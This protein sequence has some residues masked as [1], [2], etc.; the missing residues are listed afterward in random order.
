M[1]NR[2]RHSVQT[3]ERLR[4]PKEDAAPLSRRLYPDL[5]EMKSLQRAYVQIKQNGERNGIDPLAL[6]VVE[7]EGVETVLRHLRN[8]LQA[9]SYE[10]GR[11]P[12]QSSVSSVSERGAVV[13]LRDLVVQ[14]T[15]RPLLE[16][17]FPPAFPSDPE[18]EK[19]I[20]WLAA[21][22]DRGLTRVYT[23]NVEESSGP[24]QHHRLVERL[25]QRIDD[26]D[27]IR[28]LAKFLETPDKEGDPHGGLLAPVL[29]NI[30]FEKIDRLLQQVETLGRQANFT[31]VKCARVD[32]ELI[33]LVDRD[34]HYDWVLPAVQKR[35][36]EELSKLKYNIDHTNTQL[37]DLAL[38]NKLRFLGF[39]LR[40]VRDRDGKTR[41]H[42]KR[43]VKTARRR[44]ARPR[45]RLP[46]RF[47]PLRFV[48]PCLSWME[49]WP[50]WRLVQ[51]AYRKANSVQASWRHLPITLYPVLTY[52]LGW[53]SPFA[54]LCLALIFVCNWRG[55]LNTVRSSGNWAGRH[56]L[57][58]VM[59][60][61]AVAA[62]I[63]VYPFVSNMYAN[64]PREAAASSSLPPGFYVGEY[65][66]AEWWSSEPTPGLSYGLYVPPHL[67]G[68]KG[69]FPLIV[70]LHGYGE[71]TKKRIFKAGLPLAIARRFGTNSPN[72]PFDFVA[73]FPIDPTGKWQAGSAE[74]QDA[75][76]AL[77]Y[78]IERHR[79]D[80]SR[81]YLTGL[82]AGGSGVW[83]LA[84]AHP[85]KWAA[86]APLCSFISPDVAKV[87]HLPAWI[88]HGAKDRQA[89]VERE[90][91]LVQQ[92]KEAKADVRY[93][94]FPNNE[95]GIW[96]E[97]YEPKELYSWLA[98]KKKN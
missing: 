24:E 22:I 13:A 48:R 91:I 28:L 47:N 36:R 29:G 17:I 90:R 83:S 30:A 98:S 88:F 81:V 51:H 32:H 4:P 19:T 86:V 92:L 40:S 14:A 21:N 10:P 1:T 18:P 37:V 59:G 77:D 42:Y 5:C 41:V 6:E 45:W 64:R 23:V 7:A 8:D 97:A 95:H 11:A 62:L 55:T 44:R 16:A 75:M 85:D 57:D 56:K 3:D 93:T 79:I 61:C 52:L 89:P 34:C 70:F 68:Q 84:E 78:V 27:L 76:T 35:L 74:A 12:Q 65:H 94:E 46:G 33:I 38:G 80:P 72:G 49:R 15:L 53:H 60:L 66:G 67:Q 71:R 87:R 63:C 58:T 96:P 26:P 31:C 54:W 82:S 2:P 20:K 39:E 43:L 69:P 73:F 9:R 50:G 25:R